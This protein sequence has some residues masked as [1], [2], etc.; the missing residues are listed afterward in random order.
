MNQRT[1]GIATPTLA[2]ESCNPPRRLIGDIS[3]PAQVLEYFAILTEA[4][5]EG[6]DDLQIVLLSPPSLNA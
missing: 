4:A 3:D 5:R 1:E 6:N 2:D